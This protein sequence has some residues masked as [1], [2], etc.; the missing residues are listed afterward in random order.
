MLRQLNTT[1]D[2]NFAE[3]ET[4]FDVDGNSYTVRRDRAELNI[5]DSISYGLNE[6]NVRNCFSRTRP[7]TLREAREVVA[8]AAEAE[9]EHEFARQVRA[10]AWDNRNDVQAALRGDL[11]YSFKSSSAALKFLQKQR[12]DGGVDSKHDAGCAFIAAINTVG[13]PKN[14]QFV[15]D[16]S[17][18]RCAAWRALGFTSPAEV[19]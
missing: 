17:C 10:G 3:G 5:N 2:R 4:V 8:K 9:G 7:V 19:I 15:E 16:G 13:A 1:E 6:G 18:C 12:A 11:R 14:P